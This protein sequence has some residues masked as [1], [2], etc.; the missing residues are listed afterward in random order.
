[1]I[2]GACIPSEEIGSK[3]G[4]FVPLTELCQTSILVLGSLQKCRKRMLSK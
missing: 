2:L 3:W 1:L 4:Y